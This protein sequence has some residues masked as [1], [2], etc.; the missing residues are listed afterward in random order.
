M[1][2][3]LMDGD[4]LGMIDAW[5]DVFSSAWQQ[6]TETFSAGGAAETTEALSETGQAAFVLPALPEF[7]GAV[8]LMAFVWVMFVLLTH[9][10]LWKRIT[11]H[12]LPDW[13][14]VAIGAPLW[15]FALISAIAFASHLPLDVWVGG[16]LMSLIVIA[17]LPVLAG[18]GM[19]LEKAITLIHR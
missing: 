11:S 9:T 7:S 18:M 4:V 2:D 3:K 14:A 15:L 6:F 16:L 10:S 12:S 1:L 13:L 5:G 8:T 17:A 19:L